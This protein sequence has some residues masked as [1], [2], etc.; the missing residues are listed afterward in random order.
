MP[1]IMN[2]DRAAL[3]QLVED[4][5]RAAS[6]NGGGNN[7]VNTR[8]GQADPSE[9]VDED[10]T[11]PVQPS[12]QYAGAW[13]GAVAPNAYRRSN[14][15]P[16][17]ATN[18]LNY[19]RSFIGHDVQ[20][21]RAAM[22]KLG[23]RATTIQSVGV[24]A[25]GGATL[26]SLFSSE[27]LIDLPKVTPFASPGIVRIIPMENETLRWTKV[28]ARPSNPSSVKE[29]AQYSKTGVSFAPITL[30]AKKIGEIIPFTEEILQSNAVG[31]V[32]V[33]SELVADAFAFKYNA[34]VTSGANNADEPEGVLTNGDSVSTPF[35]NTDDRTKADSL[36]DIFHSM[37]S[38]YRATG[39]IWLLN[40]LDIA[41]VRKLKDTLGRYLWVDGFGARPDTL[42]GRPVF[43]N[44][45]LTQGT[46]LFGNFLK[47]Y[48]IGKREGMTIQ[49]NS[50]GTD[51]EKDITNYKFRERWDGRVHDAKAFVKGTGLT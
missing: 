38:Q 26:P 47:G 16:E 3:E 31:M 39:P 9:V 21:M 11:S 40:D 46:V 24:S 32:G 50:S 23:E 12:N 7:S 29:G 17:Q 6:D 45:D 49:V 35:V 4:R 43:E 10:G 5:L 51:W 28:T 2:M 18:I 41:R 27:V 1:S 15:K 14:I 42:L 44:P 33:I 30:V 36:I 34:L 37:P 8:S 20:G 13:R 48:I 19:F 22:T 25:D